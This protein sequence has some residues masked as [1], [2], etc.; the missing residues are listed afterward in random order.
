ML[1]KIS[2]ISAGSE[3]SRSVKTGS[4]NGLIG[5]T[6]NKKIN[7]HDS[8]NISP[9]LKFLNQVNWRLK[10]FKHIVNEKLSLTFLVSD[11]EFQTTLNLVNL[12]NIVSVEY[13]IIK[14]RRGK[15][16]NSNTYLDLISVLDKIQYDEEP[17]LINFSAL[18]VLF[19]RIFDIN[20]FNEITQK[21][22]FL[23][24]D[25]LK[26]IM[27]GINEEFNSLNSFLFTFVD[28]L[29]GVKIVKREEVNDDAESIIIQKIKV[30]NA[31]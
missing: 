8:V 25:L 5:A 2:N 21:D 4:F 16:W 14:E 28:K 19:Q 3:F 26:D 12:Q 9:A 10:D 6:Y 7:S 23:I 18:N 30:L 24:Q 13:R 1:D 15:N 31:E 27:F 29:T 17:F 11:I 20:V 22:K